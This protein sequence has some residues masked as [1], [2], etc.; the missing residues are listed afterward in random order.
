VK[1]N[2]LIAATVLTLAS[3]TFAH[4]AK[5]QHGGRVVEASERHVEMVAKDGAIDVFLRDQDDKPLKVTGYKGVAILSVNGKSQRIVLE[6]AGDTQLSGKA[7]TALP[8]RPKGVVQITP[9]GGKAISA[10]FD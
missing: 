3:P 1:L 6:P 9:P 4:D 2:L 5:P 8:A 7:A 10:K